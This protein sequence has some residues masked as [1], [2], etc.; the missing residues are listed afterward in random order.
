MM[1]LGTWA[2]WGRKIVDQLEKQEQAIRD[3]EKSLAA[4]REETK[5]ALAAF[6]AKAGILGLVGGAAVSALVAYL[7]NRLVG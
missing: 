4:H 5:T 2:E 1:A 3:L 7:F 6:A